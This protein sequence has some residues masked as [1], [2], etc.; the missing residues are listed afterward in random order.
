MIAKYYPYFL[1]GTGNTLLLS[2]LATLLGFAIGMMLALFRINSSKNFLLKLMRML[3]GVYIEIIRGTPL[4]VQLLLIFSSFKDMSRY[5]AGV[6]ALSLN[7]AAYVAEIVR[8]GIQSVDRGQTEAARSLGM[9]SLMT[10]QEIILPQA[11]KNILPALGN[12][13]I[14]LIKETAIV[15]MVGI[16]DLMYSAGI[17]QSKTYQPIPPLMMAMIIYLILTLTLS[18]GMKTAERRLHRGDVR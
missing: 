7:S 12:E 16:A 1:K 17:V 18:K 13:F 11:I 8:A 4:L 14:V 6:I 9:S 5:T 3:S 10:Y 15:S 2:F